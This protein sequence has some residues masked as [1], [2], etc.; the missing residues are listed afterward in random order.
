M[1]YCHLTRTDDQQRTEDGV[2]SLSSTI[3]PGSC[4]PSI[5]SGINALLTGKT[6]QLS[7][8][9]FWFW[10]Q[11]PP[12][13]LNN[14]G[15]SHVTSQYKCCAR[16]KSCQTRTYSNLRDS[17]GL[18]NTQLVFVFKK[19][20]FRFIIQNKNTTPQNSQWRKFASVPKTELC[21]WCLFQSLSY[22]F[23]STR[24]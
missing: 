2:T 1:I 23:K 11:N 9:V 24:D 5:Y 21:L 22:V 18:K 15:F 6:Q 7:H 20:S 13:S 19:K 8:L 10:F 12:T 4:R 3:L 14:R 16:Y 17:F